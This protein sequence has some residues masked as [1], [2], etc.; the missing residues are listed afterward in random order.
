M[1]LLVALLAV[2]G[3]AAAGAAFA[4]TVGGNGGSV[5]ALEQPE[6][7]GPTPSTQPAPTPQI[8]VDVTERTVAGDWWADPVWIGVGIVTMILLIVIVAIATRGG[9]STTVVKD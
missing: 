9:G 4:P 1:R 7:P 8:D 2:L 3:L 5:L 6:A